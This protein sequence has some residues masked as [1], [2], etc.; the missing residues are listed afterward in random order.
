MSREVFV[1]EEKEGEE[2][3]VRLDNLFLRREA[4]DKWAAWQAG[5]GACESRVVR[6]V[7][8][9][10]LAEVERDVEALQKM[11]DAELERG[12]VWLSKF[13]E[14]PSFFGESLTRA[15]GDLV[16]S[17][18]NW[19]NAAEIIQ[20]RESEALAEV[21]RLRAQLAAACDLADRAMVE[22]CRG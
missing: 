2:F 22:V 1:L 20:A 18:D 9:D 12:K 6:Y 15:I 10:E 8:E 19:A 14:D 5:R 13:Q 17:R 21:A 3:V 7:P 11:H 16:R 4:A